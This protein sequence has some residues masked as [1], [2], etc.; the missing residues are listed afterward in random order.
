MRIKPVWCALIVVK[1]ESSLGDILIV[2]H[3]SAQSEET[4]GG[5]G[6]K[7]SFYFLAGSSWD[8]S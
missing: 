6:R 7:I 2:S 4:R 5:P 1:A 3:Y 8:I